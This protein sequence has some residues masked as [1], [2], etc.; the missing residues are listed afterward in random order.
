MK[1]GQSWMTPG[2][3]MNQGFGSF[4]LFPPPR[5]TDKNIISPLADAQLSSMVQVSV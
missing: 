4:P 3:P 1:R 5:P 2:T